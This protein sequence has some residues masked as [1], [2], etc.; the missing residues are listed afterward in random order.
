MDFENII[1]SILKEDSDKLRSLKLAAAASSPERT[2]DTYPSTKSSFEEG[3]VHMIPFK[4]IVD[5]Q[6]RLY[7]EIYRKISKAEYDSLKNSYK[8]VAAVVPSKEEE[9]FKDVYYTAS[10]QYV[11][12]PRSV[13]KNKE[14]SDDSSNSPKKFES[15]NFVYLSKKEAD[16]YNKDL[17]EEYKLELVP[18]KDIYEKGIGVRSILIKDYIDYVEQS[19]RSKKK[20]DQKEKPDTKETDIEQKVGSFLNNNSDTLKNIISL[21]NDITKP[22]KKPADLE[23]LKNFL[24]KFVARYI[25]RLFQEEKEVISKVLGTLK[26]K[27]SDKRPVFNMLLTQYS[28]KDG[29]KTPVKKEI[30]PELSPKKTEPSVDD[31]IKSPPFNIEKDSEDFIQD[32]KN[33]VLLNKIIKA[34]SES[35][36]REK[37]DREEREYQKNMVF[38]LMT[39]LF[40]NIKNHT[41]NKTVKDYIIKNVI[42]KRIFDIAGESGTKLY[43]LINKAHEAM[44]Q[45]EI[46]KEDNQSLTEAKEKK[47]AIELKA[48]SSSDKLYQDKKVPKVFGRKNTYIRSLSDDQVKSLNRSVDVVSVEKLPDD[49]KGFIKPA[50]SFRNAEKGSSTTFDPKNPKDVANL[51]GKVKPGE[52]LYSVNIK[53]G[54]GK[55]QD[56]LMP[57]SQI[58]KLVPGLKFGKDIKQPF[59]KELY[60]DTSKTT[61]QKIYD[62]VK[63]VFSFNSTDPI[64]AKADG[65][66]VPEKPKSSLPP[67]P[68]FSQKIKTPI[69][70]SDLTYRF[71]VVDLRDTENY[72]N[73]VIARDKNGALIGSN[74]KEEARTK[75]YD[76]I[77]DEG[78]VSDLDKIKVYQQGEIK[79]KRV[80]LSDRDKAQKN[81]T[82]NYKFYLVDDK[83]KPVKDKEG[84]AI[85]SDSKEEAEKLA[86]EQ[87]VDI[88]VLSRE[89]I[90][91]SLSSK[92]ASIPQ[93]KFGSYVSTWGKEG[94]KEELS[95]ED[96]D[97][98]KTTI[99]FK[100]RSSDPK[101]PD[102]EEQVSG[103]INPK[104]TTFNKK[105]NELVITMDDSSVVVFSNKD[106]G[107]YYKNP[108][109]KQ[110]FNVVNFVGSPL[111]GV[112]EKVFAAPKPETK[113]EAYIRQRIK[114][115]LQETELSQYMGAQGPEVKKK[116]L[117]E[118]MKKYEWGF[119][120]S[121]DPYVRSNGTEK[122]S[123]VS[124]LVHELGDEGVSIFNSYAPK[125]YEIARP[126]DL[127][128]MADSPLGSQMAR[129]FEPNTLTMRG[130][131][132]AESEEAKY[133]TLYNQA[134]AEVEKNYKTIEDLA[135]GYNNNDRAI[136]RSST[137]KKAIES[138]ISQE[139]GK[140]ASKASP[141]LRKAFMRISDEDLK[142]SR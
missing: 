131:R 34:Y 64:D 102:A 125:G 43:D 115:A 72:P 139:Y 11:R 20:P 90:L 33:T 9:H 120:E 87:G 76:Y 3:S 50:S 118:Y 89:Q 108:Q 71:Y 100:V 126:D 91:Q 105:S 48:D 16:S 85:G 69:S 28:K 51:T 83:L 106:T 133:D 70:Y 129:P 12:T 6:K 31:K 22:G 88:K 111:K 94:I 15:K 101:E 65:E 19:E 121:E 18:L 141:Q 1:Y 27:L 124:K 61:G 24:D 21:Y 113:L 96:K 73:G 25:D 54:D 8:I 60:R 109:D 4:N 74:D 107:K 13:S 103:N 81:I 77:G 95:K 23:E 98:L 80:A 44:K 97:K 39:D 45:R 47:Y 57:L 41:K 62:K 86:K 40:K 36:D 52:K 134:K 38:D 79:V 130:G 17:P 136:L 68:A 142:K 7:R 112:L 110:N 2:R 32:N 128:D 10:K 29:G 114:R 49:A 66:K 138:L 123:I 104:K 55:A 5:G 46:Q 78:Y 26:E 63:G 53:V 99:S 92:K 137:V 122:H 140:D 127:N 67:E 59:E 135:I 119:Q 56:L 35:E 117:E 58:E 14:T 132:V 84:K 116:R 75:G 30:E 93:T 42:K 82:K 37:N